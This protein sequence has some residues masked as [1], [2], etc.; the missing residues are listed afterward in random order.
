MTS[1]RIPAERKNCFEL[2]VICYYRKCAARGWLANIELAALN[3]TM[4]A[5]Y[6][7]RFM[8]NRVQDHLS[9][10]ADCRGQTS[11]AALYSQFPRLEDFKCLV[12]ETVYGEPSGG[13][14]N[15]RQS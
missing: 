13:L 8:L 11:K 12:A 6:K 2:R 3:L 1:I 9:R 7:S 4:A 5:T 10:D 14:R 15:L